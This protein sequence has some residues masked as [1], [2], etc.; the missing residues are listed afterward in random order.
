MML[1]VLGDAPPPFPPLVGVRRG[2]EIVEASEMPQHLIFV[3]GRAPGFNG[4]HPI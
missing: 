2:V 4:D 1:E 3:P